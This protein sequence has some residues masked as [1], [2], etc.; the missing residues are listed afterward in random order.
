MDKEKIIK[1]L[2]RAS[3]FVIE[4]DLFKNR[5]VLGLAIKELDKYWEKKL[6][7]VSTERLKAWKKLGSVAVLHCH[8][9]AV[10]AR[11]IGEATQS[12]YTH[13]AVFML[14][15]GKPYIFDSQKDGFTMKPFDKWVKKYRYDYTATDASGLITL[16]ECRKIE[17]RK[18]DHV[19]LL[20]RQPIELLTDQWVLDNISDKR[21]YCSEAVG[22]LLDF[23]D[24]E[25]LS[26]KD[27]RIK[28]ATHKV[29]DEVWNS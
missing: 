3:S 11:L 17:G 8:G 20:V 6:E 21:L 7:P 27:L 10:I 14:I 19:S 28:C 22:I 25:R 26:P 2:E 15:D 12:K 29:L 23:E 1:H 5:P 13:T 24:A 18:Y 16:D 9:E 4:K